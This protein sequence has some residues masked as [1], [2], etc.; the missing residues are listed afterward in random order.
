MIAQDVLMVSSIAEFSQ[1]GAVLCSSGLFISVEQS[2][3]DHQLSAVH[4]LLMHNGSDHQS[5]AVHPLPMPKGCDHQTRL[6]SSASTTHCTVDLSHIVLW[7]LYDCLLTA[8]TEITDAHIQGIALLQQSL[9]VR[10]S[11]CACICDLLSLCLS[12]LDW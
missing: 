6:F 4:P 7:L 1:S 2:L 9:S 8:T 5:T 12:I 3:V 11:D 10:L